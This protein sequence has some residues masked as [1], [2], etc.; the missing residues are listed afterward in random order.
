MELGEFMTHWRLSRAEM[1][2]LLGKQPNTLD[3]WLSK[4][5]RLRTPP[6]VLQRLNELHLLFSRWELEDQIVPHLRQIY[7]TV[8]DRRNG[9]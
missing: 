4:K 2:S 1:A 5:S 3:H 9:D 6:D 8:R 7:E